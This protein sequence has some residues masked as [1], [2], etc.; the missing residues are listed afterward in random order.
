MTG[1]CA[2]GHLVILIDESVPPSTSVAPMC[3][4]YKNSYEWDDFG[5]I[6]NPENFTTI[7]LISMCFDPPIVLLFLENRTAALLSQYILNGLIIE[8]IT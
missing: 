4:F 8:S 7:Y 1:P 6:S 2:G 5:E 3:P